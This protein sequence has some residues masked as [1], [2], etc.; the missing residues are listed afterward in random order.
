MP[1]LQSIQPVPAQDKFTANAIRFH[2][3][4]VVLTLYDA[5]GSAIETK[6]WKEHMQNISMPEHESFMFDGDWPAGV[7]RLILQSRFGRDS[8]QCIIIR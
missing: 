1:F 3:E 6:V 2:G 5:R 4:E 7:Y 8:Q